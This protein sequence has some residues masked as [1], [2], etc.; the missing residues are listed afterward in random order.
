MINLSNN[1]NNLMRPKR[2]WNR[3]WS[4]KRMSIWRDKNKLN[5]HVKVKIKK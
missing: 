1:S 4:Y 2:K 5:Y 3:K